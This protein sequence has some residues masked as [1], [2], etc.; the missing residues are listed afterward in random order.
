MH[1]GYSNHAALR[2]RSSVKDSQQET[3]WMVVAWE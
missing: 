3:R 1:V 2:T